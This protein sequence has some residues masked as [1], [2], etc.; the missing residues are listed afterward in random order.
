[1]Y[2][3]FLPLLF[4][5]VYGGDTKGPLA[6]KECPPGAEFSS[7]AGSGTRL[8]TVST[9]DDDTEDVALPFEFPWFGETRNSIRVSSNGL[10]TM[11]SVDFFNLLLF[12]I[13]LSR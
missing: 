8:D 10:I 4:H 13:T 2:L 6:F 7:I 9:F 12:T 3:S 11:N 1:M 5:I